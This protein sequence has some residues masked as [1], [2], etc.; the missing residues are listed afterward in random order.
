MIPGIEFV[1]SIHKLAVYVLCDCKHIGVIVSL[2]RGTRRHSAFDPHHTVGVLTRQQLRLNRVKLSRRIITD[3]LGS[4]RKYASLLSPS[5]M[6]KS[7]RSLPLDS[8][9]DDTF[10]RHFNSNNSTSKEVS[11]PAITD[12]KIYRNPRLFDM[13]DSDDDND[14]VVL[15]YDY[16]RP[17]YGD[18]FDLKGGVPVP[19]RANSARTASV[20]SSTAS[21]ASG[22]KSYASGYQREAMDFE[23]NPTG[24]DVPDWRPTVLPLNINLS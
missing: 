11:K 24:R 7:G 20:L 12:T 9:S 2:E 21:T 19:S 22:R 4:H 3:R 16:A 15:E 23:L 13:S 1:S 10:E 5:T 18:F 6:S 14:S 8:D 17:K